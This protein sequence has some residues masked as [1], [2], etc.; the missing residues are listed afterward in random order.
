MEGVDEFVLVKEPAVKG[1]PWEDEEVKRLRQEL[2]AAR[3]E[4]HTLSV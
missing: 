3:T 1:K 4:V 2:K